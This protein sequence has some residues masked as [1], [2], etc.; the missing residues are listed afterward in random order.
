V[1][2]LSQQLNTRH[3]II[4]GISIP[5]LLLVLVD[6]LQW[7][8][9]REYRD[10]RDWVTHTR[11]VMLNLESFLTCMNDA[12]TGQRG[13]LLTHKESYLE[14]YN[15]ALSCNRD[16]LQTLR[17]LTSDDPIQQ[18]NLDR[19]EPLV[20]AK[21]AELAQTVALEK[22]MDHTGALKIVM[23]D[24][25][26][27]T[28]DQIR[29]ILRDMDDMQSGLLQQREEAYQQTAGRNAE[30]S[31]VVIAIG[32]GF[33]IAIFFLLRRL[34]RM[35]EMIKICAWS[36]LIEYEGEWLT[37]EDY[38]TRRFHAQITHGMSD[39]EAKKFLMLINEEKQKEAA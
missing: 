22:S 10:A 18:K 32:F 26:K 35:H 4:L 19:L 30:M 25:G 33:I 11:V 24:F 31:G 28:M 20:N 37:I 8:S 17:Q 36:K 3:L 1:K 12:E 34:E 9:V 27:N 23:S 15:N 29:A 16:E 21:F 2:S 38:L 13:Y 5:A 6:W 14:P 39:V 7:Q